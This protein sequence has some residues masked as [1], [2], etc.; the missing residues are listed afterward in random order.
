MKKVYIYGLCSSNDEAIRYIGKCIDPKQRL[1]M[2]YSQRNSKKSHKNTWI[3]K[4]IA[5]GYEIRMIILEEVNEENWKEK[6]K[7]Y[8][9]SYSNLTNTAEGGL[10]GSTKRYKI[11]YSEC[12]D[13][14]K[15]LNIKSKSEYNKATKLDNFPKEVPKKPRDYFKESWITWG[16]FLGTNRPQDNLM[17]KLYVSY[18]DAKIWI[19]E[20]MNINSISEWKKETK[21]NKIPEFIPNRP[22]RYYKDR[23]WISWVDFLNNKRLAN[24]KRKIF[25]YENAKN[26]M[27]ELNIKTIREYKKVQCERYLNELPVHPHLTYKNKGFENYDKFF[28][29]F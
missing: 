24:N 7:E 15:S 14:I 11:E 27:K 25:S 26:L 2:H 23:G 21:D 18:N 10:G 3:K 4:V 28:N 13:I 19:N 20:N 1:K 17:A 6:E 12:K 9:K 16:D 5:E 22:E 8:I 29:R